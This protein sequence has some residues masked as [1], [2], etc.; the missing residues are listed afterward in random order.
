MYKIATTN[1]YKKD[2]KRI[3]SKT[4]LIEDLE[5]VVFLLSADD[6]PLPKKYNDHALQGNYAG[7]REC[8]I[9]PN[10]LLVYQKNKKDLILLLLRTGS[11]SD[12][13]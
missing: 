8:H 5:D 10:W 3:I 2:L 11:H 13:F 6:T 4:R 1:K 9:R 7:Y 12:I